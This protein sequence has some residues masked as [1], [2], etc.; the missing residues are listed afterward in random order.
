MINMTVKG[1]PTPLYRRLKKTAQ[2][3]GRSLN[4]QIIQI[5]HDHA[6]DQDRFKNMRAA[7]QELERFV[8]SLPR[9]DDSTKLIRQDRRRTK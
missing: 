2:S 1:V 3:S 6:T 7:E 5:L 9:V 4:A 8:S